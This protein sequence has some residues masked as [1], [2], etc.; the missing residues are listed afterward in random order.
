MPAGQVD[1]MRAAPAAARHY[2]PQNKPV[3][4]LLCRLLARRDLA[5]VD[6]RK[7]GFRL[8]LRRFAGARHA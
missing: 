1:A 6:I 2:D 3:L 4:E 8:A 5:E 7:P